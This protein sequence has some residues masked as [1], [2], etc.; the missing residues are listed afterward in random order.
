MSI[1]DQWIAMGSP[2]NV[3]Y[4]LTSEGWRWVY[5]LGGDMTTRDL[6]DNSAFPLQFETPSSGP[7]NEYGL[8]LRQYVMIHAPTSEVDADE[9]LT[10]AAERLGI[11]T[12]EYIQRMP[13][14]YYAL[15]AIHRR[16]YADA[17]IAEMEKA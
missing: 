12:D 4:R 10:K 5:Y 2:S 14:S 8:T 13:S 15:L 1:K 7:W 9:S 16:L 3:A 11:S 6:G 17:M